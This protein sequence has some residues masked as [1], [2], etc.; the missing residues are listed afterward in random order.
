MIKKKI[1]LKYTFFGSTLL[2]ALLGIL[3]Y[4]TLAGMYKGAGKI[5][6]AKW[7]IEWK[8]NYPEQFTNNDCTATWSP[9]VN[10]QVPY[11]VSFYPE[12]E[13]AY[14]ML[15]MNFEPE[16]F[17]TPVV[18]RL[19]GRFPY[20][21][22]MSFHT[23]D[24]T[25]GD[26]VSVIKDVNI[27]PDEGSVNP[28]QKHMTRNVKNRDYTLWLVPEGATL[29]QINK[30]H[31]VVRIPS[32]VKFAPSVLRVYRPDK[33]KGMD[34]GVP[35]PQV[36]AFNA[37]NGEAVNK[38]APL[39]FVMPKSLDLEGDDRRFDRSITINKNIRHYRSNGAGFYPN[40]HNA[41][42]VSEFDRDL[43]EL[44]IIKWKAP[45]VPSTKLGGGK[46]NHQQDLRYW[47]FCLGGEN[48]SN[49]SHCLVDD[50][51]LIDSEGYVTVVLGKEDDELRKFSEESGF[52]YIPWGLHF[53]PASILRHM[54]GETEFKNSIKI[55]PNL[56]DAMPVEIQGG[57]RYIGDYS[58][59][60]YYC[61]EKEFKTDF[62]NIKNFKSFNDINLIT[63]Y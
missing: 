60:G 27:H 4:A 8:M 26:Y 6:S 5:L 10:G 1:V 54:E 58:P 31:N 55:V 17:K 7:A 36:S 33:G 44:A 29:P 40:K 19:K 57:E 48:A 24:A 22:Y 51:A 20:A 47:S 30:S 11:A 49:T 39:K 43:G 53:R 13:A 63:K 3:Y 16:E 9:S 12:V 52:N 62:C 41:Y 37:K 59:T 23:Y 34:G 35:L 21:R 38:C 15:P 45:S 56:N 2:V 46:F 18:Y 61:S 14:W 32:G 42:L 50:E 28:Y 25:T